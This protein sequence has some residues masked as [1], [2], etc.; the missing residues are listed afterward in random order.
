MLLYLKSLTADRAGQLQGFVDDTFKI[1]KVGIPERDDTLGCSR[2]PTFVLMVKAAD[3][4]GT[5]FF[6]W[7]SKSKTAESFVYTLALLLTI[8]SLLVGF[9]WAPSLIMADADAAST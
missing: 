3:G 5:P 6:W 4:H 2:L 9:P 7:F 8:V 1:N